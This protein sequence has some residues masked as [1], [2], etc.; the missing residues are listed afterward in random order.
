[1][2]MVATITIIVGLMAIMSTT[3]A[4]ET[5]DVWN[6]IRGNREVSTVVNMDLSIHLPKA[7]RL[8]RCRKEYTPFISIN[9]M[10]QNTTKYNVSTANLE[11]N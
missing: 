11:K 9:G 8:G 7:E 1:M 10:L 3:K 4:Q 2:K 6:G 5:S